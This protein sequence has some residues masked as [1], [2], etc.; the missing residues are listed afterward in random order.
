[1][2]R[3][4]LCPSNYSLSSLASHTKQEYLTEVYDRPSQGPKLAF[5]VSSAA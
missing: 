1:M 3:G 5:Q 2:R 4:G